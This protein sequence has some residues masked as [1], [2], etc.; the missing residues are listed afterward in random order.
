MKLARRLGALVDRALE[1][2]ELRL[3]EEHAAQCPRCGLLLERSRKIASLLA[4]L[5]QRR[6]PDGILERAWERILEE[7]E[8]RLSPILTQGLRQVPLKGKAAQW[9][10]E[11]P[12]DSPL[13]EVLSSMPAGKAPPEVDRAVFR[14]LRSFLWGRTREARLLRRF[15]TSFAAA[16]SLLLCIGL[17]WGIP[18]EGLHPRKVTFV[19]QDEAAPPSQWLAPET[20][21]ER[22]HGSNSGR[23]PSGKEGRSKGR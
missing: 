13:V 10:P 9:E 20:I 5:P 23:A 14:A 2:D 4:D 7:E 1:P 19:I 8:P 22:I 3:L 18:R 21:Q 15:T 11:L 16:A 17:W 6:A 12:E